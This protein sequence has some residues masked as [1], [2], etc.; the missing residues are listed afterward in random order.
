VRVLIGCESSGIVRDAFL[1]R[2]HEAMSCDLQPSERPGPHY[3]GD[4]FDVIDFPW[5]LAIFHFPCTHTSVSG[6]RWFVEKR[7]DGRQQAGVAL[8]MRG[9]RAAAHIPRVAFEH[10][11]SILSTL[12]REPDQI[13][14]PW[15]FWHHQEPGKGE[16]KATCLWTRGLPKLVPTTP[17]E[18]GRHQACWL[19]PPSETR[20]A[21]RARTYPGIADAM[22]EQWGAIAQQEAA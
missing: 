16:R 13:I 15:Q 11:I 21:D 5:D 14:E 2:S 6:A 10:P 9:W 22:A 20:A 19:A 3:Q 4:V 1:A 17:Q 8:F 7:M 18:P 12:F